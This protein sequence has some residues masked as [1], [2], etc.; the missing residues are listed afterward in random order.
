MRLS[1]QEPRE[2]GKH[3]TGPCV[4]SVS[5]TLVKREGMK[6]DSLK[7]ITHPKGWRSWTV[8]WMLENKTMAK[9][10]FSSRSCKVSHNTNA[11]RTW[12]DQER[13]KYIVKALE[14]EECLREW[15][16]NWKCWDSWTQSI[17]SVGG[18]KIW[19]WRW[20]S[21]MSNDSRNFPALREEITNL[22]NSMQNVCTCRWYFYGFKVQKV[23]KL[24][25][26]LRKNPNQTSIHQKA[27]IK[28]FYKQAEQTKPLTTKYY[29]CA[30][31]GCI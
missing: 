7:M 4:K 9:L 30:Q 22:A 5:D 13:C 18:W 25:I 31:Q 2:E 27:W 8:L 12:Q 19:E 14:V 10:S 6:V 23:L 26:D 29:T 20:V 15:A 21:W 3:W 17:E 16:T 28:D 24:W 11:L 1:N